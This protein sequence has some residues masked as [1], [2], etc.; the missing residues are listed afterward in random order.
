MRHLARLAEMHPSHL[1]RLERGARG[2][3]GE[4]LGRIATALDVPLDAITRE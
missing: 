1:S 4:V 2:A 3:G